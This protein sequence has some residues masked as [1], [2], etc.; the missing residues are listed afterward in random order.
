MKT[1]AE[2]EAEIKDLTEKLASANERLSKWEQGFET[3]NPAQAIA[4]HQAVLQKR[5]NLTAD[6]QLLIEQLRAV[7]ESERALSDALAAAT[8]KPEGS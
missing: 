6:N 1:E 3:T 8:K 2:Y 7:K 5:T 4:E